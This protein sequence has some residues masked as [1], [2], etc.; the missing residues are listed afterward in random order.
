MTPGT[1]PGIAFATLQRDTGERFQ[2]LRR[3]LG[4]TGFG[5]NLM[6]ME[7]RQRGRVHAHERQ[8]EV[9]L[10]LEGE[11]TVALADG[12]EHVV[13][14]D[15][16]VR[17]APQLRRQMI[18]AGPQRLV[19]LALGGSGEHAGRDGRAWERFDDPGPGRPPQE[20]PAPAD[21]PAP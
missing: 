2:T 14:P 5:I 20:V 11:L 4:V 3:Q 1:D 17:I 7:P 16:L 15:G 19:M 10:V 8:E 12:T 18:N 13:G 21:L 6:V 9:F